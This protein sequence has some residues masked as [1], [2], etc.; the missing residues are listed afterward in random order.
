[1]NFKTNGPQ[2][3]SIK[4][5]VN[6]LFLFVFSTRSLCLICMAWCRI[7]NL[8]AAVIQSICEVYV[9]VHILCSVQVSFIFLWYVGATIKSTGGTPI[10]NGRGCS[11]KILNKTL[12]GDQSRRGPTF[13]WPLKKTILNFDYMNRINMTIY[14]FLIFLRA[15]S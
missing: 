1:M 8:S 13:F 11:S 12:K 10:W 4:K 2:F 6:K 7:N 5:T 15:Q 3:R 14:N 9:N